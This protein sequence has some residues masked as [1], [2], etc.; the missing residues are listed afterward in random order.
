MGDQNKLPRTWAGQ[1]GVCDVVD[2]IKRKILIVP[3]NPT[4]ANN[5]GNG[6][7]GGIKF[8]RPVMIEELRFHYHINRTT[9]HMH[10]FRARIW[11]S[12]AVGLFSFPAGTGAAYGSTNFLHGATTGFKT[13]SYATSIVTRVA[14]SVLPGER[15][16]V[17]ITKHSDPVTRIA[18]SIAYVEKPDNYTT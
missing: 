9:S 5:M 1:L 8:E 12:M 16:F 15:L 14:R 3:I 10:K 17:Q 13:A 4:T 2:A 7:T 18:L 11:Q 6:T